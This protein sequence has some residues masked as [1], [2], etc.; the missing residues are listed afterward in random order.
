MAGGKSQSSVSFAVL[1]PLEAEHD[2]RRLDIS[3]RRLRVLLSLLLLTPGRAVPVDTLVA[4]V[5]GSAPPG[6][7]GNALQALVSRLR[8]TLG[9]E[10]VA[11]EAA[12]YR[13]AISPDQ[14]DAH[15]FARLA[16]DGRAALER[17]DAGEAAATLRTALALWRGPALAELRGEE[18]AEPEIARL[19]ELRLGAAENRI[20]ADLLL[21][22]HA[23]VA[24]ELPPLIAAHPLRERLHGQF[25]RA[26]FESGRRVEALAAYQAARAAFADELGTDPSP[27]LAALHLSLLRRTAPPDDGRPA[28]APPGGEVPAAAAVRRAVPAREAGPPEGGG[29]APAG[30]GTRRGNLRAR[31]TSFVGR[32]RDVERARSLL[33]A[34]RLVTL[35]GP[36]GAGKTRL[37]VESGE[38]LEARTPDGVWIVELAPVRDPEDVPRAVLAALGMRD[39]GRGP[40]RSGPPAPEPADLTDRLVAGL[41]ARSQLVI[42]DNCE[43]LL[44]AVARLA[45]RILAECPSVR[46]LA[47]SREPLGITGEVLWPVQPLDPDHARSLFADRAAAAR[48]GYVVDGDAEAVARICAELD[49]M[50][51]A[52]ELAAARLRTLSAGQIAERLD[53]RFRLLTGGSRTALPRHQTLRAVVEWSWSL[54]DDR[55]RTLARRLAAF[56]GGATLD[57]VET[58]CR[59]D[60]LRREDVFDVLAKLVDKSLV[61]WENER[62]RM[63]ETIRAY[64]AERLAESGE[65]HRVRRAH[66]RYFTGAA[67]AAEPELRRADQVKWIAALSAE[68]DNTTTALRW[69]VETGDADLAQRLVGALGWYWFLAGRRAEGAQ[70]AAEAVALPAGD[71]PARLALALAVRGILTAGG[72]NDW[73][74]AR[75]ALERSTRIAREHVPRPWHPIV[76]LAEPVLLLF[77]SPSGP[78]PDM[79][80]L[81]DDPDPWVS[82]C[83][84]LVRSHAHFN[85]G[86]VP[87]GEADVRESLDRFRALGDRWGTGSAMGTLAEVSFLHGDNAATVAVVEEALSMIDGIGAVEDTSHLRTRLAVAL[88]ASGEHA[89]AEGVVAEAL[90][91]CRGTGDRVGEA[92]VLTVRGDLARERGRMRAAGRDYEEALRL[93]SAEPLLFPGYFRGLVYAS[94]GLLAEQEGDLGAARAAHAEAVRLTR[95]GPDA[96]VF[97]GVLI[98][99]AGLVAREGDAE[100]AAALLGA[101]ARVRG[102]EEVTGFDQV[103][104]TEAVRRA[105]GDEDFARAFARGRAMPAEDVLRLVTS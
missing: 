31:L 104:I 17:G 51:L 42:L 70:R 8:G 101:S 55:E 13:L 87:E 96:V 64:A 59:G 22:R 78:L 26:L 69:S 73:E 4:G 36:G 3:G 44:D 14:V 82:A 53:D 83:A 10:L 91:I 35:L 74:E 54:L 32:E 97:G 6:G 79:T 25:M 20:D 88:N 15:R 40:V 28:E 24:R 23:E 47:T 30:R 100:A 19:D 60:G 75:G 41:A 43:H 16:A 46:V 93:V 21:G 90:E 52:I 1:G 7:V 66:A 105:L 86:R 67:E 89:R 33:D 27:E 99:F 71:D 45:D 95:D 84:Y 48:P 18:V 38:A 103:R 49:G 63:L 39:T 68:H 5:W 65:Q 92:G 62:Y 77:L 94:V 9:R 57:A 80:E 2:G 56:A 85:S 102:V 12:G 37:A 34:H 76:S 50:P 61:I 98:A 58:V 72:T 81:L 11:A 29:L